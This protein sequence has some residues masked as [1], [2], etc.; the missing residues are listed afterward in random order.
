VLPPGESAE[1]HSSTSG[2]EPSMEPMGANSHEEDEMEDDEDLD[3]DD[4]AEIE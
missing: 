4:L 3:G 2:M 1:H